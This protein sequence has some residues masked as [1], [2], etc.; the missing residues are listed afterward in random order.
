MKRKLLLIFTVLTLVIY[1]SSC[2][3]GDKIYGG[4]KKVSNTKECDEEV[5]SGIEFKNL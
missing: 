1:C 5:Y 4:I 3:I 2:T